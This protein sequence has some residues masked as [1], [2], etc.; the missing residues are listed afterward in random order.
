ML[1]A[2]A[3]WASNGSPGTRGKC[4][5]C[6][7]TIY[8]QG[9]TAAHED[10]PKPPVTVKPPPSRS[11]SKGKKATKSTK[12]SPARKGEKLV[13]VESPTKAKTIGRYLGAATS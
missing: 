8:K 2:T 9:R 13:I 1:E 7:G 4:A 12:S 10:L 6:G 11:A 3:E 5:V